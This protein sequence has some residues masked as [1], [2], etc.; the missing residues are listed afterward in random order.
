MWSLSPCSIRC[1]C[2]NS[3]AANLPLKNVSWLIPVDLQNCQCFSILTGICHQPE[4]RSVS[5]SNRSAIES[6][7]AYSA[8]LLG[9]KYCLIEERQLSLLE[10]LPCQWLISGTVKGSQSIFHFPSGKL[11]RRIALTFLG[12]TPHKSAGQKW[13]LELKAS[14]PNYWPTLG[15]VLNSR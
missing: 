14:Q 1:F 6:S 8:R 12:L 15:F 7:R 4:N 5:L 10:L 9:S 13:F 11:V 3:L 2:V